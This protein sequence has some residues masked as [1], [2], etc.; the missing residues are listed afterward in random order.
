MNFPGQSCFSVLSFTWSIS[1][2]L[3]W[4]KIWFYFAWILAIISYIPTVSAKPARDSFPPIT[5]NI[6]ANFINTNF[7]SEIQLSTVL[8][9]L[10]TMTENYDL[11]NLHARQQHPQFPGEIKKKTSGWM[12]CL[13]RAVQDHLS[14]HTS[15]LFLDNQLHPNTSPEK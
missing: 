10:F 8:F 4:F 1:L 15:E 11:L 13:S 7:G 9:L 3:F 2:S 6:F 12:T 14:N 5:F